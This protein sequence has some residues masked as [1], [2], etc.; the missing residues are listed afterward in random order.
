[1]AFDSFIDGSSSDPRAPAYIGKQDSCVDSVREALRKHPGFIAQAFLSIGYNK[2][3]AIADAYVSGDAKAIASAIAATVSEY[4]GEEEERIASRIQ[5]KSRT[6]CS[7]SDERVFECL[8]EIWE[9]AA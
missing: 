6:Y 8:G 2:A 1:M 5:G 4:L 7:P 9:V 3:E